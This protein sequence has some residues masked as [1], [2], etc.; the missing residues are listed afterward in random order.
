MLIKKKTSKAEVL[1]DG[2]AIDSSLFS[3]VGE[4]S[5]AYIDISNAY[6]EVESNETF[7]TYICGGG[8]EGH[9]NDGSFGYS[10]MP[11][12]T[13][14]KGKGSTEN[15]SSQSLKLG[16]LNSLQNEWRIK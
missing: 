5:Y 11:P 14:V 6:H 12:Y 10:F 7:C 13:T 4:Y 3:T 15:K 16:I 9:P 8:Y 1:L 2:K